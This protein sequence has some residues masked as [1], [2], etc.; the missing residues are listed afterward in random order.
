M[1]GPRH[2]LPRAER[3]RRALEIAG[4][5]AGLAHR[6]DLLRAGVTRAD[7]R[8]EVSAGRW[9]TAGRHTVCV[10][11]GLPLSGEA[12]LWQAVWESGSGAV[13]DGASALVAGGLTGFSPDRIDVAVP[14]NH[15]IHRLDGVRVH[16]RR[17][18]GPTR[19]AG[20]PRT[21]P[22]WAAL[23]AA[24][25]ARSDRAAVLVLCLVVQQ[26][27]VLPARLLEAWNDAPRRS[28]W[29]LLDVSIPDIC[30]GAQSLGELD[31]TGLCRARG[32]PPP[33]R[34]VVRRGARG[35]VYL[36]AAWEDIGLV[37]EVDG[38]HH[39]LALAP[40]DDALRQ[41]DVTLSGDVVLRIPVLGLRLT[42][43]SFMDQVV[44]AHAL[45]TA[46]AA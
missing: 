45:L 22:E 26:R 29:R 9:A 15:R 4:L 44:R 38:G 12:L 30:D 39:L 17:V 20:I 42:P 46:R 43:D 25:W 19:R 41:N 11:A 31:F 28:R 27:L 2:R 24:G 21:A 7:V 6:R 34:Q 16:R 23:R 35:R 33:S 3:T 32:L 1:E 36:D 40:I 5:H 13:L 14:A 18:I 10:T 37:V 8:T